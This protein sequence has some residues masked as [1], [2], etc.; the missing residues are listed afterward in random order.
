LE[1][2]VVELDSNEKGL[3]PAY[4]CIYV[5]VAH[6]MQLLNEPLDV[7]RWSQIKSGRKKLYALIAFIFLVSIW[8]L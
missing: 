2:H 6:Y 1:S 7:T 3:V 8:N 5:H 4:P